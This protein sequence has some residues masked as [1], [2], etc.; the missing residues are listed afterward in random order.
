MN[1][2]SPTAICFFFSLLP[3]SYLFQC[4][5]VGFVVL[6]IISVETGAAV[7]VVSATALSYSSVL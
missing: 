2:H 1:V 5:V 7:I 4:C 6:K 3:F